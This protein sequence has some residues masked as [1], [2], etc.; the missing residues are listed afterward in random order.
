MPRDTDRPAA[1]PQQPPSYGLL[2]TL[3]LLGLMTLALLLGCGEARA[4]HAPPAAEET[5]RH[6]APPPTTR[7]EL[8]VVSSRRPGAL[9]APTARLAQSLRDQL[10]RTLRVHDEAA[11]TGPW[12][13]EVAVLDASV[14]RQRVGTHDA[15]HEV[16]A[17]REVANPELAVLHRQ[18]DRAA[19]QK[20]Y[21][22]NL[23]REHWEAYRWLVKKHKETGE[24]QWK[25]MQPK[26]YTQAGR[27][28][29]RRDDA[30]RA[31]RDA[32]HAL[33][34][35]PRWITIAEP[36]TQRV[37]VETHRQTG[38]LTATL[39]LL[40]HGGVILEEQTL[41][42]ARV[43]EDQTI[44]RRHLGR[45]GID[46]PDDPLVFTDERRVIEGLIADVTAE[47]AEAVRAAAA[48]EA[49]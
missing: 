42:A 44:P 34:C 48:A 6:E 24:A 27:S 11:A 40:D 37:R 12:T 20:S 7:V 26:Y 2:A 35:A 10:G 13:A 1:A 4:E 22:E 3:G 36:V 14:R 46:P 41:D 29:A 15:T 19:Q 25:Q 23:A 5:G 33:A 30:R 9:A 21:W 39:T 31:F 8:I 32:K 16:D 38:T 17:F 49:R 45:G 18:L 28:E 47:A 43:E